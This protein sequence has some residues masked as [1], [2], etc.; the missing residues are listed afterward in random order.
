MSDIKIKNKYENQWEKW[1]IVGWCSNNNDEQEKPLK[2]I[3]LLIA[4]SIL[5]PDMHAMFG[6][7]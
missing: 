6:N 7:T 2:W 4:T 5:P 1:F 3:D